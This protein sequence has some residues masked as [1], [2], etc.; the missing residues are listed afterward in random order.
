MTYT[1]SAVDFAKFQELSQLIRGKITPDQ[2]TY[3]PGVSADYLGNYY[4]AYDFLAAVQTTTEGGVSTPT[5]DA[6][7]NVWLWLRGASQVNQGIGA[8]SQFIRSYSS[9]QYLNYGD[10]AFNS[11]TSPLPAFRSGQLRPALALARRLP[12]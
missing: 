11:A 2:S 3:W 8:F 10:S 4:K 5:A 9:E 7:V 12:R 6:D 1:L